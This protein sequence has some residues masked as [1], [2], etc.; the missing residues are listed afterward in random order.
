MV[1]A[2]GQPVVCD[3]VWISNSHGDFSGNPTGRKSGKL[4]AG[5]G[6]QHHVGTGK[7]GPW[8]TFGITR[9]KILGDPVLMIKN[10]WGG[11]SLQ[12]DFRPPSGR[13]PADEKNKEKAG[14]HDRLTIDHVKEVLA[15]PKKV[16]PAYDPRES[17]L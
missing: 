17:W 1:G 7:T 10:A 11:K 6:S 8:F 12:M 14:V 9:H 2:D 13:E 5:F 16:Y 15:K 4:T 3:D